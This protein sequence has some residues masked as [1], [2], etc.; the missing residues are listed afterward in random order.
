[1]GRRAATA[2]LLEADQP[3]ASLVELVP[4]ATGTERAARATMQVHRRNAGWVSPLLP[5]DL[6]AT[7]G[8]QHSPVSRLFVHIHLSFSSEVPPVR[9]ASGNV[10]AWPDHSPRNGQ[11]ISSVRQSGPYP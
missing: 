8:A 6:V 10:S 5:I 3:G 11:A 9:S 7:C 1:M 2:T 4:I